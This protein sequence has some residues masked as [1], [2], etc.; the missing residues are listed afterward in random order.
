LPSFAGDS[1]IKTILAADAKNAETAAA[2]ALAH[3]EYQ[4]SII[5]FQQDQIA[6]SPNHFSATEEHQIQRSL[7]ST[8]RKL[9]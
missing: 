6:Y 2:T 8:Y 5:E 4:K 1:T 7:C 3:F 9:I